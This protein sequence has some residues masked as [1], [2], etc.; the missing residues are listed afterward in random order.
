MS[1][2][3]NAVSQPH[4]VSSSNGSQARDDTGGKEPLLSLLQ[5]LDT[6]AG[7][8]L[9]PKGQTVEQMLD[10]LG[11][12]SLAQLIDETVP[13]TIRMPEAL[14]LPRPRSE[15]EVMADLRDL[16]A[17]NK[18]FRSFIGMGY[19]DCL[20]PAVIQRNILENPGW[21]TQYTP[22]Q[23]EIAQ[24]RLEALLNFQTMVSDLTGLEIS[25]AS[26]LDEGTAAAEAMTLCKRAQSRRSTANRFFV[27]DRCH[28]PPTEQ[29]SI[30]RNFV[31]R[32]TKPEPWSWW[33]PTCWP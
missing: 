28:P 22:Y 20:V 9:G 10:T 14:D 26:L 33:P 8:H 2:V 19:S 24:G 7:R 16:A 4:A 27:S 5:P 23:A 31:K 12:D 25:N 13:Q 17:R 1:H 29:F 32:P 6:F 3:V 30:T 18:V 21:Y 11:L 15:S